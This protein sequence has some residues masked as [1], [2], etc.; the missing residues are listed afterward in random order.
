MR[1]LGGSFFITAAIYMAI[2]KPPDHITLLAMLLCAICA[3][4]VS[5]KQYTWSVVLGGI[6]IAGSLFMRVALSYRCM[7]CL[8]ADALILCGIV[9]L[10]VLDKSN[11]KNL[12]RD[13]AVAMTLILL[14]FF[15]LATPMEQNTNY[16]VERHIPVTDEN[17]NTRLDSAQKPVFLFNPNCGACGELT[18]NLIQI[19]SRGERWT[20][21]Q[22]GGRLQEGHD[23][24]AGKGYE[25]KLYL[26][27]WPV[28]VPALVITQNDNTVIIRSP[29]KIMNKLGEMDN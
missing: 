12:T 6:M 3:A 24:L 22:T 10:A 11:L 13:M 15:V 27:D 18:S 9:Y 7:D 28:A 19:D 5:I 26:T 20:P 2:S 1:L 8:R 14:T 25:G 29:D 17:Y 23:Y 4:L 21:V 16:S